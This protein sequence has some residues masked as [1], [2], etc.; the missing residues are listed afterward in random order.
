MDNETKL[1]TID[2]QHFGVTRT[3]GGPSGTPCCRA[4]RLSFER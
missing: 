3:A 1:A 4:R 2:V